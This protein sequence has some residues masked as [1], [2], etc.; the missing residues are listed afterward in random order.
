MAL[1]VQSLL[2]ASW[3]TVSHPMKM[4]LRMWLWFVQMSQT[5]LV[6][7]LVSPQAA[8]GVGSQPLLSPESSWKVPVTE[9]G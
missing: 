2:P 9:L 7:V 3:G 6:T 4:H 1:A 5:W 8:S